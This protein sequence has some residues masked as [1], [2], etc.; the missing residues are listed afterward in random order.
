MGRLVWLMSWLTGC[1]KSGGPN[2]STQT[3][4]YYIYYNAFKLSRYGY[5]SAM[6]IVLAAIIAVFS[7]LQ[8]KLA[9]SDNG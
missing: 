4:M 9:K 2:N 3:I 1:K 6:G 8:F 5:G 7:A